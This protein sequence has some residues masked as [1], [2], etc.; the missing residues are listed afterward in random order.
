V[1]VFPEVFKKGRSALLIGADF[2]CSDAGVDQCSYA[3]LSS[4]KADRI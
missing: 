4:I 1:R 3:V 2:S